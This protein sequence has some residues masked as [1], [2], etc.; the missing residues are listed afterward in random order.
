MNIKGLLLSFSYRKQYDPLRT[1]FLAGWKQLAH[2]LKTQ[3]CLPR[4]KRNPGKQ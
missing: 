2:S 4:E 1:L 3:Y